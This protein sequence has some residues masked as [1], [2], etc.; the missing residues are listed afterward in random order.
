MRPSIST[1]TR[2][3]GVAVVI[4]AAGA[5][6]ACGESGSGVGDGEAVP[7]AAAATPPSFER[8]L[9]GSVIAGDVDAD[10]LRRYFEGE[11]A[12]LLTFVRS[13]T[14]LDDPEFFE[15]TKCLDLTERV[16]PRVAPD[17]QTLLDLIEA[18]PDAEMRDTLRSD[19]NVKNAALLVC[20]S[21]RRVGDLGIDSI[22]S[23]STWLEA[24]YTA[25]GFTT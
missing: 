25:L 12:P 16:L 24:R 21:G 15:R 3:T 18:V 20:T 11:G 2:W 5:L 8:A 19:V 9:P 6:G 14:S 17:V 10:A 4:V 22:R 23:S 13:T 7:A 1:R